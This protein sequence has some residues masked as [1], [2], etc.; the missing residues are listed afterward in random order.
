MTFSVGAQKLL[1]PKHCKV[2]W[3]VFGLFYSPHTKLSM[4]LALIDAGALL[5]L[6]CLLG[7]GLTVLSVTVSASV[8]VLCR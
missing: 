8:F 5:R 1:Q 6:T 2:A 7:T 3:V 4:K